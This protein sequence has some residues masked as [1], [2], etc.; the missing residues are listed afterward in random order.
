[1]RY[2]IATLLC[3]LSISSFANS[4][5]DSVGI[6][7]A[8]P[9]ATKAG[10]EIL[11]QGGNA[12]DA[13]VTVASVLA[14]VEPYGS[15]LGGGGF[16]LLHKHDEKQGQ[17]N[18][19][20]D[21][22]EVAPVKATKTMYLSEQGRV[23]DKKSKLGPLAAGIPGTPAAIVYL[24]EEYGQLPLSQT[25]GPAIQL[26]KEG[27]EVDGAY[28]K[29]ITYRV[30]DLQEFSSSAHFLENGK[31]PKKGF[32]LVQPQLAKVFEALVKDGH[33]GFYSGDMVTQMV[34]N[35]QAA[36]GIWTKEDFDNYRVKKRKPLE[37]SYHGWR[38]I[39]TPPPSAGGLTV[40]TALNILQRF[41]E[42]PLS[43]SDQIHLTVESLRRAFCDRAKYVGDPDFNHVPVST[44]LSSSHTDL[45]T[46]KLSLL[47]ATPSSDL[48]C[49]VPAQEGQTTTHFSIMD[50][51]GNRV[52]A[53]LSINQYFGSAYTEPSTGI[54]LNNEM[55][56]F[57]VDVGVPNMYGLVGHSSN[58]IAPGKR[59]VSSMMPTFIESSKGV[60]ILGTPGGSRIPSMI[61]LAIL[62]ADNNVNAPLSW[63]GKGR[64]HHQYMP[65]VI[66]YE[67]NAI[68]TKDQNAL[69]LRGH[70]LEPVLRRY[71]NM[72]VVFWSNI[73]NQMQAVSDPRGGGLALVA[74]I[75]TTE[76]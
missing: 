45:I 63:V 49:G 2:F 13:A 67:K 30:K 43:Q 26:A 75:Q 71:G 59:P 41:E 60:G 52:G 51:Q 40:L 69:R 35:V 25:L 64:Y 17:R 74:K 65:D 53:T 47:K 42:D 57:S 56:D 23:I 54:L 68:D 73:S 37:G 7:S 10:I 70:R 72:Q 1:M 24:A 19:V 16:F 4:K 36:G 55:D 22:R 58:L 14:V 61:L 28:L 12:F 6:A 8:H 48:Q 31:L 33:S 66:S 34:S 29:A 11:K 5:L 15:G 21:A 44:L 62:E 39:T 76:D 32:K 20:I 50:T 27:F 38:I 9:L 3:V 18:I 46:K